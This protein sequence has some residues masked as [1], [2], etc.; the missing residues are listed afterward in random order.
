MDSLKIL[1][2]GDTHGRDNW[3]EWVKEEYDKIVFLGDYVDSYVFK[4]VEILQHL[5]DIIEF[6]KENMNKVI[7]L[8]GNHCNQYYFSYSSHGCSGFRTEMYWDL[9]DLYNQ[10]KDLFQA[11]YQIDNYLFTHAGIS[12]EWFTREYPYEP[13]EKDLAESLNT[14]F[15]M[16]EKSLFD[17]GYYRGGFQGVGGIFWADR[18]ETQ[19]DPLIGIHQIVGHTPIKEPTTYYLNN[20]VNS[21]TSITYIDC[22]NKPYILE[23]NDR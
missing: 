20:D 16:N 22:E 11:A 6:K 8:L 1:C 13:S 3:K 19:A 17:V 10:N 2:I 9:H 7:L 15:Q 23:I 12:N 5:K 14:A 18:R 21:G 4:N